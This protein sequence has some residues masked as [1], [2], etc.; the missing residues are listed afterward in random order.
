[1]NAQHSCEKMGYDPST[2]E[3]EAGGFLE[4]ADQLVLANRL[5]SGSVRDT[6]PKERWGLD[7]CGQG[8]V[9]K[10]DDLISVLSSLLGKRGPTLMRGLG[11]L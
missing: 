6:T 4:L 3:A 10:S 11:P 9:T 5:T 7:G 2:R 8:S 1:M